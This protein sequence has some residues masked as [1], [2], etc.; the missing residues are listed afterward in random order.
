MF[1]KNKE[2]SVEQSGGGEGENWRIFWIHGAVSGR[3]GVEI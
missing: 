3:S 1:R 2:A